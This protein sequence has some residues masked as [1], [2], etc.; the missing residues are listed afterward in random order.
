MV[1]PMTGTLGWIAV[2]AL[3]GAGAAS[4]TPAVHAALAPTEESPLEQG[5][6]LYNE[7]KAKYDMADFL[8]A[9][10]DWTEAYIHDVL[11]DLR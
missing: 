2:A 1:P 9:I 11:F 7:G 5:K 4:P 8:G 3:L 6:R 10:A